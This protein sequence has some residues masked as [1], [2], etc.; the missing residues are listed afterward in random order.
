MPQMSDNNP[1]GFTGIHSDVTQNDDDPRRRKPS[2]NAAT[3]AA[4]AGS[5]VLLA[6]AVA[7]YFRA[8]V[9]AFFRTRVDYLV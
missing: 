7:F 1:I 2:N 6:R 9:K 4:A 5:R 3:G 8:P